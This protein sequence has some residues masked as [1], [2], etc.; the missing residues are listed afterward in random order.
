MAAATTS[1]PNTSPH[2]P[3]GFRGDDE[4]GS[5]VARGHQLEEQVRRFGL[6]R[7]VA[8][9]VDD[10]QWVA[11][12]ADEF[13]LQGAAVVGG[14][15]PI[16]PLRCGG[17]QDPVPG[18]AGPD[19]DADRQVRLPGSGW[20]EEHHIVAGGDEV[21][22]AQVRDEVAFEAAGV[23]EVELLQRFP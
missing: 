12:Q 8:H 21:Q 7:D 4:A 5:F 18:L 20:A 9:F 1:S 10:E 14:G 13:D 6:E 16:D 17:E 2:R 3:N 22:G 15:Q 11:G 23:V 19:R